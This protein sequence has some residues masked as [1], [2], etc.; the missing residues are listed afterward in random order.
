[1]W[2]SADQIGKELRR[3]ADRGGPIRCAPPGKW[4]IVMAII[5]AV[6]AFVFHK[7]KL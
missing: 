6:P 5:R 4:R 2:A 3:T 1:M 7:T